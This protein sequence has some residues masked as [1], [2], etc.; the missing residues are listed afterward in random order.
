[1]AYDWLGD[2]FR[3]WG[4]KP[5]RRAAAGTRM[6][7]EPLDP[8]VVPSAN[9]PLLAPPELATSTTPRFQPGPDLLASPTEVV[10]AVTAADPLAALGRLAVAGGAPGVDLARS[11]V[12]LPAGSGEP[13]LLQVG[14]TPGGNPQAAVD[15]FRLQRDVAWANPNYI[16]TR[17]ARAFVPDDTILNDKSKGQYSFFKQQVDRAWDVTTGIPSV[18]VAVTDDG[19]KL[20]HPDLAPNLWVNLAPTNGDVNGFDFYGKSAGLGDSDPNPA[21]FQSHGTHVAGIIGARGNNG[22][23]V[24]GIAGGK[25]ASTGVRLMALRWDD[26]NGSF[27]SIAVADSLRYATD[28]GAKLINSSYD[29]NGFADYTG[30]L[31]PVVQAAEN[32]LYGK[33]VLHFIAAGN[34]NFLDPT[35]GALTQAL[36]VA[37]TDA[38]DQRSS[39]SNYGRQVDIAAPGSDVWSTWNNGADGVNADYNSIS[40][41]SMASPNATGVAALI[42]SAH[43]TWTRDQ[44]VAQLL[45]SADNI[46]G[47][48]AAKYKDALGAGRANAFRGVTEALRPPTL[49][50]TY[51]LPAAGATVT[52]LSR[53]ELVAPMRFDP[54]TVTGAAFELREAGADAAFDTADDVLVPLTLNGNLPYRIG[55]DSFV[56]DFPSLSAGKYRFTVRS[57]GST[58]L[59]DPFGQPL[60]GASGASPAD[61]VRDFV[62][63]PPLS[64]VVFEDTNG[65]G[66]AGVNDV[67]VPGLR[68]Y[69]DANT[70]GK[71]DAGERFVTSGTGGRFAFTGLAAGSYKVGLDPILGWAA[72]PQNL[73]G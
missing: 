53:F 50:S 11:R 64:G 39:F 44:V 42:W 8:R 45:G 65:D 63:A 34:S 32:Y 51:G 61:F 58:G 67:G 41:T 70:N 33:G 68:V 28:H 36:I 59:K 17:D 46:Y 52:A 22:T 27:T 54:A 55:T 4:R 23:G 49:G 9:Y 73:P 29:F 2:L 18:I 57:G 43:P 38:F 60:A 6:A 13:A 31:D 14:L 40:G 48:N 71:Y 15:W 35:V 72:S 10:V 16:V 21:T 7:L 19:V 12:V 37:S 24:A 25:D 30:A 69:L 1:M 66:A 20:T 62:A 47:V 5:N 3:Q 56:F 26:Y